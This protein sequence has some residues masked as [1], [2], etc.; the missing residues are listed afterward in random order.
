MENIDK[1]LEKYEEVGVPCGVVSPI[2][3]KMKKCLNKCSDKYTLIAIREVSK[4]NFET[5]YVIQLSSGNNKNARWLDYLLNLH[6]LFLEIESDFGDNWLIE[7][8]N[9]CVDDV[10]YVYIG[11]KK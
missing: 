1:F 7:L 2:Y 10:H 9:D 5:H 8:Q 11:I 3:L 4:E 6:E